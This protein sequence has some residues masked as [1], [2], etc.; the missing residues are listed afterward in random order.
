MQLETRRNARTRRSLVQ[1]EAIVPEKSLQLGQQ[2]RS[3]IRRRAPGTVEECPPRGQCLPK[4]SPHDTQNS[5]RDVGSCVDA[6]GC[7]DASRFLFAGWR[8]RRR[9][10]PASQTV[11]GR[12]RNARPGTLACPSEYRNVSRAGPAARIFRS[13]ASFRSPFAAQL[14]SRVRRL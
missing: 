11:A 14:L 4:I 9:G 1:L 10:R 6:A 2:V 8:E 13:A 5:F 12:A 3:L 7:S